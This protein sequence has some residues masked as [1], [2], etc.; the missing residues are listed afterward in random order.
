MC[1][2]DIVKDENVQFAVFTEQGASASHMAAA[3]FV[4]A[5]SR[6]PGNSGEDSDAVGAYTQVSFKDAANILGDP[7]VVTETWISLPPHKRPKSWDSVEDPV[8]PLLLNLYGHPIAGLLWD[9][10]QENKLF[11]LG[12]ERYHLGNVFMCIMIRSYSCL[13]TLM[14]TRWLA[15][16][17]T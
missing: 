9:K 12:F 3:K 10:Y 2:E 4:Y 11:K 8:V 16:H 14:T 1:R 5:V 15:E 13:P 6:L 17:A 7:N